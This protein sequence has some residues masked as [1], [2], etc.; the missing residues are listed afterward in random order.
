M[1][2]VIPLDKPKE[3]NSLNFNELFSGYNGSILK[4]AIKL[5]L[6]RY[7][8]LEAKYLP[9]FLIDTSAGAKNPVVKKIKEITQPK[10][11]FLLYSGD[12]FVLDLNT[13]KVKKIEPDPRIFQK[14]SL[15]KLFTTETGLAILGFV[16]GAAGFY[17]FKKLRG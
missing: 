2:K 16:L 9:D 10:I 12:A 6:P 7:I 8:K 1:A 13:G 17:L 11:Y 14:G 4:D 15:Q 3:E 5:M